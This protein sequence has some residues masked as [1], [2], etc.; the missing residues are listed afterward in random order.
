MKHFHNNFLF[1][2][3]A[4]FIIVVGVISYNRFIVN[5]DYLVGYEGEC[6]PATE[7]CFVGCEDDACAEE[8]FYTKMIKYAP[9]LYQECGSDITDCEA[10]SVCLPDDRVCSITYNDT[11]I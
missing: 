9:D 4:L 6:D 2:I 8:Y 1:Y 3:L 11:N 7:E 5:Q 10:A